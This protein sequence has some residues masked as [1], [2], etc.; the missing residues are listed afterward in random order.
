MTPPPGE[1]FSH[2][3]NLVQSQNVAGLIPCGNGPSVGVADIGGA[4]HERGVR[5]GES[6]PVQT[7][8]VFQ[9]RSRMSAGRNRPFVEFQ[10]MATDSG[11]APLA[12]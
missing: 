11:G 1:V 6:F 9:S 7:D 3:R 10:L 8:V 2:R 12:S 5:R 4:T